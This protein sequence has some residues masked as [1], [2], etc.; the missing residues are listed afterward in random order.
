M[1][2]D[3]PVDDQIEI[4]PS[5][6]DIVGG[7]AVAFHGLR[8]CP[9]RLGSVTPMPHE[10][11]LG[12]RDDVVTLRVRV[13][14]AGTKPPLWLAAAHPGVPLLE[15]GLLSAHATRDAM[16]GSIAQA[17]SHCQRAVALLEDLGQKAEA[18]AMEALIGG[19]MVERLADDVPAMEAKLRGALTTLE[20]LGD[21][22][23]ASKACS[24]LADALYLQNR[25][26]D[27]E[28]LTFTA[29]Q[30]AAA[31]IDPQVRWRRVRAKVRA[32]HGAYEEAEALA[33]EAVA[34]ALPTQ[35][36]NSTADALVDL[37]EVLRLRGRWSEAPPH[38]EA[39]R[40]LY[41]RKGN[42][43]QARWA[44]RFNETGL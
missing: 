11:D 20:Q 25:L 7:Y 6:R 19:A 4:D 32:R 16:Q 24:F 33:R 44:S 31:D 41:V 14:L 30:T 35:L 12:P 43:V 42:V 21:T 26:D 1:P 29:E 28:A 2:P 15:V 40:S 10:E 9:R 17:R 18:A 23:S 37:A 27:A 3:T 13:D 36:V 39:A 8:A 22:I 34:L 38:V 5:C